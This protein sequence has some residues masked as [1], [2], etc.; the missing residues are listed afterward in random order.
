MQHVYHTYT[1]LINTA[2]ISMVGNASK[3]QV[4]STYWSKFLLGQMFFTISLVDGLVRQ[5]RKCLSVT[6]KFVSPTFVKCGNEIICLN[7]GSLF[8]L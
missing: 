6:V 7:M 2:A 5:V 4:H 8:C 3:T 1:A